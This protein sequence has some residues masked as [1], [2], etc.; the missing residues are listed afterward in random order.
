MDLSS[1]ANAILPGLCFLTS[2]PVISSC[3]RN[4]IWFKFYCVKFHK[5]CHQRLLNILS[6]FSLI[7]PC[8]LFDHLWPFV[9]NFIV[10]WVKHTDLLSFKFKSLFLYSRE[11]LF[12][13]L[14]A[15]TIRHP[16]KGYCQGQAPLAAVLL[17]FM[18]EV[19]AFWTFTEI[20]ER[21]L[22]SYYDEG[23]VSARLRALCQFMLGF[24]LEIVV[25][26]WFCDLCDV[27]FCTYMHTY[28]QTCLSLLVV[29]LQPFLL[30]K[31]YFVK[32]STTLLLCFSCPL[33]F[34]Y[35]ILF[36]GGT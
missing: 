5:L 6:W 35:S 2:F 30:S 21:Y 9:G 16:N 31:W 8:N 28:M 3:I 18:P 29:I 17:M 20:C 10:K 12:S 1:I 11:S 26:F 15:Y 22:V 23:L 13:I 7:P 19:E 14:K 34:V 32:L 36:T 27:P 24:L 25:W 33:K 4:I